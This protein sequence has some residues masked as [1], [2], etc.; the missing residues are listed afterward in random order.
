MDLT[1]NPDYLQTHDYSCNL[2]TYLIDDLSNIII[3]YN[4]LKHIKYD[5]DFKFI[6]FKYYRDHESIIE[7]IEDTIDCISNYRIDYTNLD[8]KITKIKFSNIIKTYFIDRGYENFNNGDGMYF[9]TYIFGLLDNNC[10]FLIIQ[11]DVFNNLYIY[12]KIGNIFNILDTFDL[13]Y[14]FRNY[15]NSNKK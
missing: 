3:N 15:Q 7:S 10:Y 4:E 11:N 8:I 2:N 1:L 6:A 9:Y 14:K 12:K 5:S 13:L